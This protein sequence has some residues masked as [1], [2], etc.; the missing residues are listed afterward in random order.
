M[1]FGIR[2]VSPVF[3]PKKPQIVASIEINNP[4]KINITSTFFCTVSIELIH[5]YL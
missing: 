4:K 3:I 2:L 5:D 1:V